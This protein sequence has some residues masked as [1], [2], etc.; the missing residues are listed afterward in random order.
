M[1][2]QWPSHPPPRS[3]S[4]LEGMAA[5]DTSS[6]RLKRQPKLGDDRCQGGFA[7]LFSQ[8]LSPVN[9]INCT[10]GGLPSISSGN[11]ANTS[12]APTR[13]T[14]LD[15]FMT[16][17]R[18]DSAASSPPLGPRSSGIIP[19]TVT[20][21]S[22]PSTSRV[23]SDEP[24]SPQ[25]TNPSVTPSPRFP[26][27]QSHLHGHSASMSSL[28]SHGSP[29]PLVSTKRTKRNSKVTRD[30]KPDFD[31]AVA[32]RAWMSSTLRH[33]VCSHDY[34]LFPIV[35]LKHFHLLLCMVV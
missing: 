9:S 26:L 31:N 12:G 15:T 24:R 22:S 30:G 34:S 11:G 4:D 29:T 14:L 2:D 25:L 8:E 1:Q 21:S 17:S 23:S 18:P 3:Q 27:S 19:S 20:S 32:A 28:S 16:P 6:I 7:S 13:P 5:G 33:K 35:S 10:P